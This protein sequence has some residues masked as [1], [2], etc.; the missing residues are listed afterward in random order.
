MGPALRTGRDPKSQ[1]SRS[2]SHND[3]GTRKGRT[4]WY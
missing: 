4:Q 1:S 2:T 3:N